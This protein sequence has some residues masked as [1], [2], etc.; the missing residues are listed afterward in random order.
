MVNQLIHSTHSRSML[1]QSVR[2]VHCSDFTS[3]PLTKDYPEGWKKKK[4]R[5]KDV[6][7]LL[8]END[9]AAAAAKP[10]RVKKKNVVLISV[11]AALGSPYGSVSSHS[12]RMETQSHR[13]CTQACARTGSTALSL[14]EVSSTFLKVF[15]LESQCTLTD[16]LNLL[17]S[18]HVQT[19]EN[20][21]ILYCARGCDES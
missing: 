16:L 5:K 10:T 11:A 13:P 4:E 20:A 12:P 6:F 21:Y 8:D 15:S 19:R 2:D 18:C 7:R 17:T 9:S 14:T 3:P 1:H